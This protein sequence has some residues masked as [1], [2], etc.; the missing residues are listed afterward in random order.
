MDFGGRRGGRRR[1]APFDVELHRV[2]QLAALGREDLDAV[3]LPGIVRGRD[4]DTRVRV[5][6]AHEIGHGGRGNDA[7]EAAGPRPPRCR[8]RGPA[9]S[10]GGRARVTADRDEMGGP[11]RHP[12]A[13]RRARRRPGTRFCRRGAVPRPRRGSVRAKKCAH[14]PRCYV[15]AARPAR[16]SAARKRN[17]S[18]TSW[19]RTRRGAAGRRARDG[20]RGER[21]R[22]AVVRGSAATVPR[23]ALRDAPTTRGTPG[24]ARRSSAPR[25]AKFCSGVL[26]NPKPGSR[27]ILFARKF[28]RRSRGRGPSRDPAPPLV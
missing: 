2:G 22:Q 7:R 1:D 8:P 4:D 14:S 27:K 9:R 13:P 24:G 15:S 23:N 6:E 18:A 10:R 20:D 3:V 21:L 25:S 16:P 19:T 5:R 17:V 26:P 12:R 28:R 11:I